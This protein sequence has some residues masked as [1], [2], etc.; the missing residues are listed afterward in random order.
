MGRSVLIVIISLLFSFFFCTN[1]F[2]QTIVGE[3]GKYK[4]TLNEFENAYAKNVGGWEVAKKDSFSQYKNFMDL[5]MNFRMKLRN[6]QVRS[7]DT[8]S[9]LIKELK[10]Y[11]QQIGKSYITEKKIIEPGIKK[12]Y[13][14][15]KEE[16]RVSHIMFR[17][18]KD[19]GKGALDKANA[20][21][22]SIKNGASFE[23]MA[24]KYSD[25]KFSASKGGDIFYVTAGILPYEFEDAMYTLQPGEVYP[26]PVK[27]SYGYHLIKVTER[28]KRIPKIRASHILINY[29]NNQKQID[30]A[31]AKLLADSVL[32]LLRNGASFEDL[33]KKYSD[34]PGSASKGGDLGYFERRQMV[35]PFDE[36]AFKLKVGEISDLVQTN[37]GYHIIKVTDRQA[38]PDFESDRENLKKMYQKQRYNVDYATY[39]D[40]LKSKY[41]YVL[42]TATVNL[43]V[44]LSDSSKFGTPYPKPEVIAGKTLYSCDGANV[45]AQDFL[46]IANQSSDF[47][48]KPLYKKDEVM[49]AVN[50][51]VEDNLIS[52]A[53]DDL[54]KTDPEFAEL[55]R[56]Y[57]NGVYIFKLQ[58]DEVWNKLK[59]DSTDIYNYWSQHKQDYMLPE[60]ISFGEI[61]S[62]SDSLIH[63]YYKDLQ[64]GAAFD[65]IAGLY[66]ERGGKKKEKGLY[67]LQDANYSDLS[68]LAN[69]ITNPD[70][71]SEPT[72]VSGGYSIFK[73]YERQ[74]ARLKT[75][76]EAKAEASGI[77]QEKESK[78]LEDKYINTLKNIYHPVIYYDELHKAFK[79]KQN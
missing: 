69:K 55:M 75:F 62:A 21:L 31:G 44:A 64:E 19:G 28:Q 76:E 6:A 20:I 11:K 47:I 67:K 70:D 9:S 15:R 13:D 42:D 18:G 17:P 48:G 50:K 1:I 61:F 41:N 8:D 5:Y 45:S 57:K 39:I 25:D 52:L 73:L 66:T 7:L 35:I 2:S 54:D 36:A 23:E 27:T 29:Y 79:E 74:P 46:D 51:Q 32:T 37:Y 72:P 30:S 33:A 22:D 14:R 3:F 71:F 65:S 60:K 49:K 43:I 26:E 10:D 53:A 34:D 68:K 38:Y 16:L 59:I 12:L 58:E 56:E 78:R 63:L 77:V 24:K 4:I 40:S